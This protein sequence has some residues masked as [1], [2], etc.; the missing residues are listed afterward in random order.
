MVPRRIHRLGNRGFSL[1][2]LITVIAVIGILFAL[3]IPFFVNY[4]QTATVKAGAQ[5]MRTALNF[6][7]QLAITTRQNICVQT[8]TNRYQ[9][10]QGGCGG[11]AWTGPGTDSAG[12][13][14]LKNSVTVTGGPVTFTW[15]G[16][17]SPGGT[18]TV[19]GPSG[20]PLTVT[21][22]AA[23]RITTP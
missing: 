21:V 19:T 11:T 13:F 2:E 7:R 1:P 20:T 22:S 15:L 12:T 17:A 10:R 8:V 16:A 14:S 3:A 9:F 5:E 6:A 18:M 4:F 23:G